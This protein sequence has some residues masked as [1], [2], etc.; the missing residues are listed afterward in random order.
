MGKPIITDDMV[1]EAARAIGERLRVNV[2]RAAPHVQELWVEKLALGLAKDALEAVAGRI[3]D[4]E[5]GACAN[6]AD[7][8]APDYKYSMEKFDA[9]N[10]AC[11]QI[12]SA[13]RSQRDIP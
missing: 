10:E 1:T 9:F 12:A 5:R 3:V 2:Y 13:I 7:E 8:M 11:D 6:I 4:R